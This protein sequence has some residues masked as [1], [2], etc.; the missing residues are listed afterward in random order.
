MVE[1][2]QMTQ[3]RNESLKEE[4]KILKHN[5]KSVLRFN[6]REIGRHLQIKFHRHLWLKTSSKKMF[7]HSAVDCRSIVVYGTTHW[8]SESCRLKICDLIIEYFG[9]WRWPDPRTPC[10]QAAACF[11]RRFLIPLYTWVL[12]AVKYCLELNMLLFKYLLCCT[13]GKW[14][15]KLMTSL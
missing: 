12:H 3:I 7:T 8:N 10:W 11:T 14:L 9:R 5:S 4:S 1:N 13:Q 6:S 15:Q 2:E